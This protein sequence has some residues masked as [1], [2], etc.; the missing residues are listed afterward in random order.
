MGSGALRRCGLDRT[1]V[2]LLKEACTVLVGF[3]VSYAQALP[4]WKTVL[5]WLPLGQDVE[6]S[7]P[8][9]ATMSAW[10]LS[11]FPP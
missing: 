6:L 4:V 5:S 1:G 2:V 7:A 11:C 10:T 3:K 8:S 9:L